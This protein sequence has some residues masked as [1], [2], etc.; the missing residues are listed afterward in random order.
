MLSGFVVARV[1]LGAYGLGIAILPLLL[2]IFESY[3]TN[4]KTKLLFLIPPAVFCL[5]TSPHP[6][7]SFYALFFAC[8]Y[9]VLRIQKPQKMK[10][11]I[12]F[13]LFILL[14]IFLSAIQILP[15]FELLHY[16]NFSSETSSYI[17]GF[18]VPL[19]HLISIGIPNYFGNPATY[20]FWGKTDYIETVAAIGLLP[21]FFVF[22]ACV[23]KITYMNNPIKKIFLGTI[24]ITFLLVID[25]PIS[26]FIISLPIP[27]LSTDPP[28][29]IFFLTT[30]SL[31][32]LAGEGFELFYKQKKS[33]I[34]IIKASFPFLAGVIAITLGTGIL[35]ILNPKNVHVFSQYN[36]AVRN[37]IL[38]VIILFIGLSI[39]IIPAILKNETLKRINTYIL[40]CMVFAIG[41][42]NAE[43]FLP[44]S[45]TK[46][47]LPH[48][49]LF[50]ELTSLRGEGRAFGFGNATITTDLATYFHFYDPQYYHPLYI[51]R[52]G[53]LT[54]YA[55][56]GKTHTDVLRSD[57]NIR[58]DITL[59]P[60]E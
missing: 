44:F 18:L 40:I 31:S 2:F 48:I 33:F 5:I 39:A 60:A 52:Y 10:R 4:F 45:S 9:F 25:S 57:A 8:C 17:T 35:Y 36:V 1:S 37:T 43:K 56:S 20:N 21:C 47:V 41:F 51:K 23:S 13:F 29:R 55:N 11:G 26:R 30:F 7:I 3:L 42:Y 53:E 59:S 34:E 54:A 38:E 27:F 19:Y 28:S 15:T 22:I 50:Q 24:L 32:V 49:D 14:G 46:T 58:N 16:A 12:W 6:Q